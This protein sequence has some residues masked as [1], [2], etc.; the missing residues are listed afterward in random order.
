MSEAAAVKK[1]GPK[2]R[3][4]M[5][6][7]KKI[8]IAVLSLFIAL[9]LAVILFIG[10]KLGLLGKVNFNRNAVFD[11]G[12]ITGEGYTTIA[13]FGVDSR[14]VGSLGKGTHSDTMIVLSI[15]NQTKEAR[16]V[17]LF[18]DTYLD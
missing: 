11:N 13:L 5:S 1:K 10:G 8:F 6:K 15:N 17:S 3:R 16:M 14:D 2:K 4:R 12:I 9:V 7:K 18:R